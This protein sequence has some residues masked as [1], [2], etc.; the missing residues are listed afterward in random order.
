MKKKTEK[1]D[2]KYLHYASMLS[3]VVADMLDQIPKTN[4][5]FMAKNYRKAI[6]LLNFFMPWQ[7]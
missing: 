6:I 1:K 3:A 5:K 4:T 2:E 7:I